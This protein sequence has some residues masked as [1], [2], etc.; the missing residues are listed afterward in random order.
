VPT[1]QTYV[2]PASF[3][4]ACAT[5]QPT[6]AGFRSFESDEAL[7]SALTGTWLLCASTSLGAVPHDGIALASDGTWTHLTETDGDLV[8]Q[9]GFGHEGTFVVIDTSAMNGPNARQLNLERT[10]QDY[11]FSSDGN[12]LR[13]ATAGGG[14]RYDDT[15]VRTDRAVGPPELAFDRG[16]RAGPEACGA[17]EAFVHGFASTDA[18]G[19]LLT[20]SWA[21]CSGGL[22]AGASGIEFAADGTY[23]HLD[24]AGA[25]TMAGRYQL[26]DTSAMNGPGAMQLNMTDADARSYVS[27]PLASE[28]PLKLWLH[29]GAPIVLSAEP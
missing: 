2:P 15:Y 5:A 12:T 1:E 11:G 28:A 22:R 20:G 19:A 18:L 16:E 3:A 21:I 4:Q 23:R 24:A 25:P 10:S 9:L 27:H 29:A 17:G 13:L 7:R 26:L 8:E 14:V 6:E